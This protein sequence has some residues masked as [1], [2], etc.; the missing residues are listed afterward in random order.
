MTKHLD[1]EINKTRDNID[2]FLSGGVKDDS[3]ELYTSHSGAVYE[4]YK[5]GSPVP[6]L[7][8]LAFNAVF[9]GTLFFLLSL[10]LK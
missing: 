7:S 10:S 4:A 3:F 2:E 5:L 8:V 1:T 6:V 9:F